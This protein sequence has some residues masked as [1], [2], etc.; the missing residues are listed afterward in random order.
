MSFADDADDFLDEDDHAVAAVYDGAT[1]VSVIFDKAYTDA[2]NIGGTRPAATGKASDFPA[3]DGA[4]GSIGKT[5]AIG[6]VAYTIRN[7]EPQ[8][9]GVF[10]LLRLEA[11][12]D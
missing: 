11:P 8:D 9:D 10:V 6:G 4:A 12:D 2:L 5:L 7:R 3:G 1:V